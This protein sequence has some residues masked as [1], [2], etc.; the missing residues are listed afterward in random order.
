M[1]RSAARLSYGQAQTAF[2]SFEAGNEAATPDV[3]DAILPILQDLWRA[4]Q[5]MAEAR[6]ARAPLLINRPERRIEL[7]DKG[8][9]TRIYTPPQLEAN[10]LIEEMMVTANVCAAQTL[11]NTNAR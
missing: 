1:M 7:N 4:Y 3:A 8:K 6:D 5:C 11:K 10:R 9:I 2:D